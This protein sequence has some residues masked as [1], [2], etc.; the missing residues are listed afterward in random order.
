MLILIISRE[1][2][3][4][5]IK[6]EE[7]KMSVGITKS[8]LVGQSVLSSLESRVRLTGLPVLPAEKVS[9][10]KKLITSLARTGVWKWLYPVPVAIVWLLTELFLNTRVH[11][12]RLMSAGFAFGVLVN[13][14]L[15][16]DFAAVLL[17]AVTYMILFP[18]ALCV[19]GIILAFLADN[20]FVQKFNW[21]GEYWSKRYYGVGE[22][23]KL[24]QENTVPTNIYHRL[25]AVFKEFA[26]TDAK[27]FVEGYGDD[28]FVGIKYQG[29]TVYFGAWNTTEELDNY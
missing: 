12:Q 7:F 14:N 29:E 11:I 19:F 13:I 15:A 17:S 6:L 9:T 23:N 8:E 10:H 26:G 25:D 4:I 2:V 27:I 18:L 22:L 20:R 3:G 1:I 5:G 28:P 24:I 21:A 16:P